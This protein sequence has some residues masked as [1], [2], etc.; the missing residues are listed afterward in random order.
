MKKLWKGLC[1]IAVFMTV[2]FCCA[3]SCFAG[4]ELNNGTFKYEADFYN[5]TC[6]L[7][8]YLGN[9]SVVNVPESIDGYRVVS[10]GSECFLRKTNVVKVNIPST[11]KSI[12]ARAFMESGIREITIPETVTQLSGSAFYRCNNLERVVIKAPVTKI[13][14]NTFAKCFNL[15]SV[16]LPNTIREIDSYA[17][18]YC[19][20]LTSINIHLL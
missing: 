6:V 2:W 3:T 9:D 15:K 19:R 1:T 13:E 10:L 4:A 7:K 14:M 18:Q 8:G 12:R 20:S 11:V 5:N 16:V 17:F